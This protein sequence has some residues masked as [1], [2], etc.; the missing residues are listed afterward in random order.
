MEVTK[1]IILCASEFG[2]IDFCYCLRLERRLA[3]VCMFLF[4]IVL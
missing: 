4:I 1:E 3:F 2:P